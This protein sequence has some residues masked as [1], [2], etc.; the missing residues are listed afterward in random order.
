MNGLAALRQGRAAQCR[1]SRVPWL[2]MRSPDMCRTSRTGRT[3][4]TSQTKRRGSA[5]ASTLRAEGALLLQDDYHW[6][7]PFFWAIPTP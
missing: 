4:R 5:L 3:G 7:S 1:A 2:A 6:L